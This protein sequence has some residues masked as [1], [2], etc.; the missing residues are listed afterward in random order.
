MLQKIIDWLLALFAKPQPAKPVPTV[1]QAVQPNWL[2]VCVPFTKRWEG[3]R[4]TAYWDNAGAVWTVGYGATGPDIAEG[5]LWTQAEADADLRR[6]LATLGS[7]IATRVVGLNANQF[8]ALV[9]FAYNL[10]FGALAKSNIFSHLA[11]HD[12]AAATG[13]MLL[14]VKAG[15]VV[16]AGLENRRRAEV[17]LFN[18]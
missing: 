10:G 15:G 4:L 18:S 16:L 1:P 13:E 9:D 17:A 8:A 14:Y 6:R 2:D 11:A 5:T 3:C 12:Y 7:E